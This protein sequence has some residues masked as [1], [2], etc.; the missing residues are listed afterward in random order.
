[1]YTPVDIAVFFLVPGYYP[2]DHFPG[3][4]GRCGVIEVN[5]GFFVHKGVKDR[6]IVPYMKNVKTHFK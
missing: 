6:K 4:L 5:Q 2:V 1:M 3:F